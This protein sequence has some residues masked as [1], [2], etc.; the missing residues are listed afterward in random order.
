MILNK[1][2]K[3]VGIDPAQ[4][5]KLVPNGLMSVIPYAKEVSRSVN[6]GTPVLI[7]SPGAEVTRVL[8]RG[9]SQLLS[10]SDRPV[11]SD[12]EFIGRRRLFSRFR[13]RPA[14]D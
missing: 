6:V 8:N 4:V 9:M 14:A 5:E 12:A 13:S 10:D 11:T 7:Y 1:A 2:E 3:G